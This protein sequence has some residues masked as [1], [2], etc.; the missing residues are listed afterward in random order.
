MKLSVRKILLRITSP[1]T[2]LHAAILLALASLNSCSSNS[3]ATQTTDIVFP[4]VNVSY[5]QHVQPLLLLGCGRYGC[6]DEGSIVPLTSYNALLFQN[7]GL[8]LSGRP[9]SSRLTQ[10]MNGSLA[11][12][13][14]F[15]GVINAN[16]KQGVTQWIREGALNN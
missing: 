3:I 14:S 4:N 9:E 5:S 15:S 11:H 7:V 10:V 13:Y 2:I 16:H 6:H 1:Q 8:V 12:S